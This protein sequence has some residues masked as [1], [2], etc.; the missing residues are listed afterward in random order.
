MPA[1]SIILKTYFLATSNAAH[2]A[3]FSTVE[4]DRSTKRELIKMK[5]NADII[6]E[7][8]ALRVTQQHSHSLHQRLHLTPD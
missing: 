2:Y 5:E 4:F 8:D 7:I 6:L 3:N 1:K